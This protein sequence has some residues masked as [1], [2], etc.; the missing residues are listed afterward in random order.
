MKGERIAVDKLQLD[1]KYYSIQGDTGEHFVLTPLVG[2]SEKE[3]FFYVKYINDD[4]EIKGEGHKEHPEYINRF[5][6]KTEDELKGVEVKYILEKDDGSTEEISNPE[7][8]M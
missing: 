3:R 7:Q 1:K 6:E 4:F 8:F 5:I 2:N